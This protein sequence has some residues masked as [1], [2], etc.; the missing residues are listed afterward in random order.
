M[1]RC[2]HNMDQRTCGFCLD[3]AA[4][5]A[6]TRRKKVARERVSVPGRKPGRPTSEAADAARRAQIPPRFR[7]RVVSGEVVVHA[8]RNDSSFE[9]LNEHTHYIRLVGRPPEWAFDTI[10]T[11]APNVLQIRIDGMTTEVVSA[12]VMWQAMHRGV[13]IIPA[14]LRD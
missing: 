3:A 10:F 1:E 7:G 6:G 13:A 4:G 12:K 11:Q 8:T 2:K 14:E 9:K 5:M